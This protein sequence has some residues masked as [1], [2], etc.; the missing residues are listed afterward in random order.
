MDAARAE[1]LAAAKL[2][3]AERAAARAAT[4]AGGSSQA[5]DARRDDGGDAVV[6]GEEEQARATT[7]NHPSSSSSAAQHASVHQQ[8]QGRHHIRGGDGVSWG[9]DEVRLY[10]TR[11][12]AA[13]AA[14]LSQ[15]FA[16]HEI[17]PSPSPTTTA[18]RESGAP[19]AEARGSVV[20]V[21]VPPVS[22]RTWR[23][24]GVVEHGGIRPSPS[25]SPRVAAT[26]AA[27]AAR[28]TVSDRSGERGPSTLFVFSVYAFMNSFRST[29]N[30]ME[31][32][33][34][35]YKC[36]MPGWGNLM[37]SMSAGD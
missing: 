15:A 30:S 21:V 26:A 31:M 22:S 33:W 36:W 9:Q 24:A 1:K 16:E 34:R 8:Q 4:A 32:E 25:L 19:G 7:A 10:S 11:G 6:V 14:A 17:A 27:R 28:S 5:E 2:R 23:P 29:S 35:F 37:R 18:P 12:A 13:T 3:A 20:G